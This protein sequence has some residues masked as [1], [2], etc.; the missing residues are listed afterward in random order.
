MTEEI[1]RP[2]IL[3]AIKKCLTDGD[4]FFVK[5]MGLNRDRCESYLGLAM[6]HFLRRDIPKAQTYISRARSI[7]EKQVDM[8]LNNHWVRG[9]MN[10]AASN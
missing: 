3:R 6:V 5:A 2:R 1:D 9:V 7:D 10:R 4:E 8:Y